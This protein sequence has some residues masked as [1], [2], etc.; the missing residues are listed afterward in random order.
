MGYGH[1]LQQSET[2]E[3]RGPGDAQD[4]DGAKSSRKY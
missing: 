2:Q 1:M 3:G 4:I